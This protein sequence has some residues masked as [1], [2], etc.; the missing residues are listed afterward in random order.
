MNTLTAPIVLTK[1]TMVSNFCV[2]TH[3]IGGKI[4]FVGMCELSQVMNFPDARSNSEW[5]RMTAHDEPFTMII[6]S[7]QPDQDEAYKERHKWIQINGMP[8]CNARGAYV[9]HSVGYMIMCIETG[10]E[11][12]SQ[13]AACKELGMSPGALSRHIQ[14]LKGHKTVK[15][16]TFRKVWT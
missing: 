2:Y 13:A 10:V 16:F 9:G 4:A 14:G 12:P 3:A 1:T 7:V 15:G 6:L 5:Q 11:Y 8:I